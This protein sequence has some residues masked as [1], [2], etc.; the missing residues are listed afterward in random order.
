ATYAAWQKGVASGAIF[1][2]S[3]GNGTPTWYVNASKADG[4][5]YLNAAFAANDA[6]NGAAWPGFL[7]QGEQGDSL[8]N[9]ATM[10]TL[11]FHGG[12]AGNAALL[13]TDE[14][15]GWDAQVLIKATKNLDIVLSGA[16]TEVQRLN[17]GQWM[18]YP[19][20]QDRWAVWNFNNGSWGTL[21]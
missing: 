3:A 12:A 1:N 8:V 7:Y 9:N 10:D 15:E 18:N 11:A 4:A 19:H 13:L 20:R 21:G 17:F 16:I 6:D 2:S 14:S 5:A